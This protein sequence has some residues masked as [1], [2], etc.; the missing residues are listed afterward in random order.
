L[1][2]STSQ[3]YSSA[4]NLICISERNSIWWRRKRVAR[5]VG[6]SPIV[7]WAGHYAPHIEFHR[8]VILCLVQFMF[9]TAEFMFWCFMQ[10][11]KVVCSTVLNESEP[12]FTK[13]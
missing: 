7:F 2:T 5:R 1:G 6:I 12:I 10:N 11:K 13:N 4:L 9:W 3:G 8:L